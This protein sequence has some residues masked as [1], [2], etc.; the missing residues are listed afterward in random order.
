[1]ERIKKE[2]KLF[3]ETANTAPAKQII[4]LFKMARLQV[5][6]KQIE[7][8]NKEWEEKLEKE[9]RGDMDPKKHA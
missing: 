2:N 1:M 9:K 4:N 8:E 7:K 3:D 5:D 6:Q